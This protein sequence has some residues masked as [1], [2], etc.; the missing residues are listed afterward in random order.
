MKETTA[1]KHTSQWYDR[2][3]EWLIYAMVILV[4]AVF[5]PWFYTVFSEPKV[6]VL[7][8]ITLAAISL[9]GCKW[10]VEGKISYKKSWWNIIALA[11]A[12]V[13]FITTFFSQNF[14]TSLY[15]AEGRF[16]GLFTILNFL[17]LGW[18]V[19]NTLP[20]HQVPKLIKVSFIT[21]SVLALYGLLQWAGVMDGLQKIWWGQ[22]FIW[23][24]SPVDRVFGTIGHGN[25]FGAYLG[26]NIMLGLAWFG[27]TKKVVPKI[28]IVASLLLHLGVLLLTGSR[29]ALGGLL[30]GVVVWLI[31]W[32]LLRGKKI[33]HWFKTTSAKIFLV[34]A[35]VI[36]IVV[37][38]SGIWQK[39]PLV[40]RTVS[41]IDFMNQGNIPDR[42]S[43]WYSTLDMI[44]DRPIF[45][46]GLSTYRDVY[47]QYRRTDYKVNAPGDQQDFITPE[48]AHNEYLNTAATQGIVGLLCYLAL[49]G[50]VLWQL[51]KNILHEKNIDEEWLLSAGIFAAIIVYSVQ[52]FV[53]FGVVTTMAILFILLG[54]GLS[55]SPGNEQ[56][57]NIKN[58]AGYLVTLIIAVIVC[59]GL[60]CA[61]KELSAEWH[62]QQAIIAESKGDT[63]QAIENYQYAVLEKP[64]EYAY[65]LG[66]GDFALKQSANKSLKTNVQQKMLILAI[67]NYEKA[68]QINQGHPSIYY[69]LA[70]AELRLSVSMAAEGKYYS[71][72]SHFDEA[73]RKAVNNPMYAYQSAK[74]LMALKS[75]EALLVA[76]QYL[77]K[78]LFMRPGYRDAEALLKTVKASLQK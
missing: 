53:S 27:L 19:M 30:A 17:I 25:H 34:I 38:V 46:F 26:M 8:I 57:I 5:S 59:G 3:L 62:Y 72:M 65:N 75:Q 50:F 22:N 66:F 35:A 29:G 10:F 44:K 11:Y 15:G 36:I 23:S 40:E 51:G 28:F 54:A 56:K 48:A 76:K 73:I 6:F 52:V 9:L 16:I 74:A 7:R 64:N 49:I 42:L 55:I 61:S 32:T 24:E 14:Y 33:T 63:E 4:P 68:L 47:N 37:G 1:A 67:S 71:A 41:T 12:G 43:W 39:F 60:I 2:G 21:S 78:A 77:E 13:S 20:K 70:V 31:Y 18:L 69:N 45:G 58:S